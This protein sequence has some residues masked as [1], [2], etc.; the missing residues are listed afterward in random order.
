MITKEDM[1]RFG[2]VIVR[3]FESMYPDG[4]TLEQMRLDAPNHG[5]IRTVLAQWEESA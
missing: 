2:G 4:T 5:W 1:E 3:L